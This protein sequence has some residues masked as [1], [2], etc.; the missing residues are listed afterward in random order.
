M[1]GHKLGV[2]SACPAGS[3]GSRPTSEVVTLPLHFADILFIVI[4]CKNFRVD[5]KYQLLSFFPLS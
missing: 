4:R 1:K 2:L 3:L 5:V